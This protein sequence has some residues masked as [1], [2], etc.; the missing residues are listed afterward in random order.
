MSANDLFLKNATIVNEGDVFKGHLIISDGKIS[1]IIREE[2]L[3]EAFPIHDIRTIDLNGLLI[4]PGVIDDQVHF[5]EPGMTYKADLYS[6]SKAA[7]AGGVTSFM[8][9]P[10]TRPQTTTQKLLEEKFLMGQ[11]SSLAN[12]S[13][14]IGA[15]NDNIDELKVTDIQNVC[16][17]KVFMGAS[18]GNM[19]VDKPESLE[20]I[21]QIKRIP[22]A[23]H[24]EDES[25]IRV[26]FANAEKIYKEN[27]PVSQHPIIRSHEAC[28]VSSRLAIS[29]AERFDTRLHLLHLS[30]ANEMRLLENLTA[31]GKKQITAEVCV[32]HLWFSA[33]DYERLG[34]LIKWN[35]AIKFE[36]DRKALIRALQSGYLDVVATDHAPHTYEEKQEAYKDCPSGAPMIQHSLLV[37]FELFHQGYLSL[38]KIV[39]VMCHNPALCFGVKNRGFIREGYAADLVVVDPNKQQTI[40]NESLLYKCKWSPMQ[41]STIKSSVIYTFVNGVPVYDNGTINDSVKGQALQF[42]R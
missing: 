15:T 22:I 11:N 8:E 37:M 23:T 30:T 13:F 4:L 2:T 29:L 39:E 35:P 38:E 12:Y 24:C 36:S 6:E 40:T 20:R 31:P 26:N 5:R 21:F 19:L 25:T 41:G 14:Y 3:P 33:D 7:V 16:G 28:E 9:M 1:R 42:S 32:H 34:S 18:T 10:N 27:I 17:I